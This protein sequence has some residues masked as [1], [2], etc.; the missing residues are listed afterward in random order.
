MST[1]TVNGVDLE[2][3]S[4]TIDAVAADSTLARFEFRVGNRWIDGGHSR[5][6]IQGFFGVGH[7]DTSR[8][9]PF[10]VDSDEPSV[11]LGGNQAPNAGEYLLHALAACI[12]ATIVYHAAAR[13]IAIDDLKCTVDGDVDLRGFLR[14]DAAVRPGFEQIRVTVTLS[15]DF[16]D[17]Q[18]SQLTELSR[19]SPVRDSVTRAVPVSIDM[20]RV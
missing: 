8:D 9:A 7:E 16:D 5:S 4:A 19:F 3:L 15:G 20:V 17:A 12:T 6:A 18:F 10:R 11:L 1:S 2:R 13:G 14:L